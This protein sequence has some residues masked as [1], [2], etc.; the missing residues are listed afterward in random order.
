MRLFAAIDIPDTTK[1]KLEKIR[2]EIP[3]AGW[4]DPS[5]YHVTLQFIGADVSVDQLPV[6]IQALQDVKARPFEIGQKGLE[7][8]RTP[9]WPGVVTM[10]VVHQPA[11]HRLYEMVTGRLSE[12][13]FPPDDRSFQ[14]HVTLVYLEQDGV[15]EAVERF[16]TQFAD[17]EISPVWVDQFV[18]YE[19]VKTAEDWAFITHAIFPLMET[20]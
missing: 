4:M 10:K 5:M 17:F 16:M 20:A 3:G 9:D 12:I 19:T 15:D 1:Q 13:G 7:R 6:I 8:F 11:L 18:L 2:A 14:P